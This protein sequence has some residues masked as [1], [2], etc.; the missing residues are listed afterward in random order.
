MGE[1]RWCVRFCRFDGQSTEKYYYWNKNDALVHFYLFKDFND[2]ESMYSHIDLLY[3]GETS[4]EDETIVAQLQF[5][6]SHNS[7]YE[8]HKSCYPHLSKEIDMN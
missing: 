6:H 7:S 4:F 3:H 5:F 2:D 8:N 1:K